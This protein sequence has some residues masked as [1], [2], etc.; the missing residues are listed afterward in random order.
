MPGGAFARDNLSRLDLV[1]IVEFEGFGSGVDWVHEL[2]PV[3]DRSAV[4]QAINRLHGGRIASGIELPGIATNLGT[5]AQNEPNCASRRL[6]V[7]SSS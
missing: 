4:K 2:Q 1:G 5:I 3:G 6:P 7:N